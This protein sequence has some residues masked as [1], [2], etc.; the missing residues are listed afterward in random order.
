MKILAVESSAK[1][2]SCAVCDG[3]KVLAYS[4]INTVLNHSRTLIPM[5]YN[6]MRDSGIG[7]DQIAM[8][9]VAAGPGSYTGVRIGVSAVNGMAFDRN[10]PCVGVS[11]LAAMARLAEGLPFD[12]VVCLSM[13]ARCGQVYAALFECRDGAVSRLSEYEV[14]KINELEKR[15]ALIKKRVLL[16]GDGAELCYNAFKTSSLEVLTAPQTLRYQNAV[17]VALEALSKP[18]DAVSRPVV[19]VYLRPSQAERE[20][21]IREVIK[22]ERK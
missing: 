5:I 21:K 22:T 19:P 12:G 7:L 4:Y 15:L 17:G 16:I 13:D 8:F 9:A 3:R 2:A 20:L 18:C 6:V 10:R 1:P 14:I 11:T